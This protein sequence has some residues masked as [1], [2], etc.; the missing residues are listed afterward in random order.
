[1]STIVRTLAGHVP[2]ETLPEFDYLTRL[3]APGLR[4]Q[5]LRESGLE[6]LH[7]ELFRWAIP[8]PSFNLVWQVAS[9]PIPFARAFAA[10]DGVATSRVR[11]ELEDAVSRCR[12]E[13]G[14]F[15]FPRA[16]R[17]FWGRK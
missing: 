8:L 7:S 3:A 6:Q 10:L 1:M 12:T 13:D 5:V 9:A 11:S 2:P 15:V 4:E 17:Q 16:C 14:T